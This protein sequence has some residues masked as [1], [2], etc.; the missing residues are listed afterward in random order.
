MP[1]E[2]DQVSARYGLS[3]EEARVSIERRKV[4][5]D[6]WI[7]HLGIA[8][9]WAGL[10]QPWSL[11]IAAM[12]PLPPHVVA[13]LMA[14]L[15]GNRKRVV[16]HEDNYTDGRVYDRFAETW[17]REH[18]A[19]PAAERPAVISP[20]PEPGATLVLKWRLSDGREVDAVEEG[21]GQRKPERLFDAG[22]SGGT[23][24]E[25]CQAFCVWWLKTYGGEFQKECALAR[26]DAGDGSGYLMPNGVEVW[27]CSDGFF[28]ERCE[29]SPQEWIASHSDVSDVKRA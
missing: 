25:W 18:F 3:P 15:K 2:L 24:Q 11:Q 10:L 29:K 9:S 4:Y 7:N 14:A 17:Q 28:V 27:L 8:Q 20:A 5:G 12:K 23:L 26:I 13:L 1:T 22:Y 21:V 16:F 19:N 6:P